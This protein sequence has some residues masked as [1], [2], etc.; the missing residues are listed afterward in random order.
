MLRTLLKYYS[1][2]VTNFN[3]EKIEKFH[4][5]FVLQQKLNIDKYK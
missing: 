4:G 2:N 3:T 1:K 5:N